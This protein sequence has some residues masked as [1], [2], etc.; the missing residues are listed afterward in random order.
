M[1]QAEAGEHVCAW[2]KY[3]QHC[4]KGQRMLRFRVRSDSMAIPRCHK[5]RLKITARS[6]FLV[7]C[8]PIKWDPAWPRSC[9][10][11]GECKRSLA[12]AL[13]SSELAEE[14]GRPS[15]LF[16]C[17]CLGSL[18]LLQIDASSKRW[19]RDGWHPE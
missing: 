1:M 5:E 14:I 9:I 6:G 8:I 7:C 2:N 11:G 16:P 15:Q 4:A 17:I 13:P 19:Y 10:D 3:K 12:L 18:L